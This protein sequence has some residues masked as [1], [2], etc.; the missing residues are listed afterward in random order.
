MAPQK[1]CFEGDSAHPNQLISICCTQQIF[2][3]LSSTPHGRGFRECKAENWEPRA[4]CHITAAWDPGK[5]IC[6][7][8]SPR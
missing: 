3:F 8:S 4:R 6:N 1:S 7:L 2:F 5:T